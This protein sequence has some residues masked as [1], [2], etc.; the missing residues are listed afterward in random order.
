MKTT[1]FILSLALSLTTYAQENY[2]AKFHTLNPHINGIIGGSAT[3]YIDSHD[4]ASDYNDSYYSSF[5]DSFSQGRK[6][7][8]FVRLFAGSPGAWHM[9]HVFV[10]NR[11]PDSRDDLN[12]DGFIDIQEAYNVVGNIIIPLDGDISSQK[13]DLYVFPLSNESGS[14]TYTKE[15]GFEDFMWDLQARDRNIN[16]NIVKLGRNEELNLEGKVVIIYG[17]GS[18][19]VFP[20]TVASYGSRKIFQTLPVACGVFKRTL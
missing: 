2:L 4:T 11:C 13:S 16:D 1:I 5:G 8:A 15:A 7:K 12:F 18:D 3:I 9:Q 19:V 10:G 14:Y 20:E 6:I 17:V